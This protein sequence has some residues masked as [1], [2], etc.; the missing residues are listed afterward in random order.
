MKKIICGILTLSFLVISL[1]SYCE[2]KT[3]HMVTSLDPEEAEF[4]IKD[5]E[6]YSGIDVK[7]IRLSTGEVIARFKAEKNR[8]TQS[9]WFGGP[10]A[11]YIA[12][13]KLG[14]LQPYKSLNAEKLPVKFRDSD[15]YW[16]GIYFGAIG[17]IS[18][19]NIMKE[20]NLKAPTSWADLLSPDLTKKMT[21]SYPYTAGTGYTILAS[22]VALKGED[23]AFEY[24]KELD[25]QMHHYTKS[26]WGPVLEVG[27][28]EAAV[29]V[30]FNQDAARKG[31]MK[32]YPIELT[33]P[34]EGTGYEIGCVAIVNN[35]P[36]LEEAKKF[37]D[38]ILSE[39]V[40]NKMYMTYR[41][42]ILPGAKL[43]PNSKRPEELKLVNIDF[44]KFGSD[45]E[46]LVKKWRRIIR[47]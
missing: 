11:E 32:G 31:I 23:A 30:V 43:D 14:L 9:I 15:G 37:V 21:I 44:N 29:S 28:G 4:Y 19:K 18:N 25:K 3:L 8:P 34:K 36:E 26:G 24:Y 35:A 22:L 16:A 17:F 39:G 2:T 45:R 27:L 47:K 20:K 10:A 33:Y 7:W 41:V 6:K 42:P 46:R 12:T 1:H 5:F 38:W 40:Q 13:K